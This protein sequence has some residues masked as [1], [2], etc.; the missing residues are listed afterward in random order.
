MKKIKF[1]ASLVLIVSF[2]SCSD[3]ILQLPNDRLTPET[4]YQTSEDFTA[5]ARGLYSGMMAGGYYG[6]SMLSR[7]DIMSD[8]LI[9][10]QRGRRSNQTFYQWNYAEPSAWNLMFN[11]YLVTNRANRILD[12]LDNLPEGS[13]RDSFEGEAKAIRAFCMFDMLRLYS[14][15]PTQSPN[16]LESLGMTV[17]TTI[18]PFFQEVRPTA[19]VSYDFVVTE[20]EEARS[21]ISNSSGVARMGLDGVNALLSRVYLYLGEYELAADRAA[22]VSTTVAP[23]AQ[24]SDVWSDSGNAGV[25][26]KLDQDRNLDGIAVGVDYSQSSDTGII[27]EYVLDFE[28]SQMFESS[29]IRT[30][31]YTFVASDDEGQIYNA[32]RKYLGE[33]GQQNGI[34]DAKL[35]RAAEVQLNRAEA[36]ARLGQDGPALE[37]LD[38]V[39]SNRYNNF[40]SGNESGPALLEEILKERRLELA[41]EGHRFFDLKRLNLPASRSNNGEFFDGTGTPPQSNFLVLPAGDF[42]FQMAIPQREMQIFPELQQNPGYSAE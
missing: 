1:I 21:L 33:Q 28:F 36:L 19:Q 35:L 4:F 24:F 41:F 34:V 2:S 11:A 38:Q 22:N 20:L 40:A 26:L 17:N 37:A 15:A 7:P 5:A 3:D 9:I 16:A 6:G 25:I 13:E 14:Q 8:N 32:V 42:R 27:P 30:T 31:A 29:D 18:D 10:A 39:R 23:R 12:Q